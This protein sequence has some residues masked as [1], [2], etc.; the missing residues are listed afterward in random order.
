M[1]KY[2]LNFENKIFISNYKERRHCGNMNYNKAKHKG[3]KVY[4]MLR[5]KQE[6]IQK[7][8]VVWGRKNYVTKVNLSAINT[9]FF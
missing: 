5:E 8:L 7:P 9:I 1:N 6:G 2:E 4:S 3:R